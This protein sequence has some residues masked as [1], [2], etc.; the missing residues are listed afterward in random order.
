MTR[1]TLGQLQELTGVKRQRHPDN[2]IGQPEILIDLGRFRPEEL[3]PVTPYR[4]IEENHAAQEH[5]K[6][7]VHIVAQGQ[8]QHQI[9]DQHDTQRAVEQPLNQLLH[10]GVF[11]QPFGAVQHGHHVQGTLAPDL[12]II[13][14]HTAF[15]GIQCK[16]E[17][18]VIHGP[19]GKRA[20]VTHRVLTKTALAI[21][22]EQG[23][24][25]K[26]RVAFHQKPATVSAPGV[27]CKT[28]PER[29]FRKTKVQRRCIT[30]TETAGELVTHLLKRPVA[31]RIFQNLHPA[32][33][34]HFLAHALQ[35]DGLRLHCL[36]YRTQKRQQHQHNQMELLQQTFP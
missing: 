21:R 15:V 30:V 32:S 22:N 17:G 27:H 11:H 8:E 6:V 33:Q 2:V 36:C 7:Q 10:I 35:S 3:Q 23:Q 25:I 28:Q 29:A 1:E 13:F 34:R 19:Q 12:E 5:D 31:F 16:H 9:V 18:P 4:D 26:D 14:G 20:G 24:F